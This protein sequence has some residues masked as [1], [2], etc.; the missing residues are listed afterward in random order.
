M[1][2]PNPLKKY[3]GTRSNNYRIRFLKKVK[4]ARKDK[5]RYLRSTFI[6]N[7]DFYFRKFYFNSDNHVPEKRS[8]KIPDI[9]LKKIMSYISPIE[10]EKVRSVCRQ[11]SLI[12]GDYENCCLYCPDMD[13]HTTQVY[14]C[15]CRKTFLH[16]DCHL[17]L[18]L[19]TRITCP[20]CG[21]ILASIHNS[22]PLNEYDIYDFYT[23]F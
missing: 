16:V 8:L 20:Y 17:K 3:N 1:E 6:L 7:D 23:I 15:F 14:K 10:R 21:S 5:N 9:I 4:S 13:Q 18:P 19:F 22:D 2:S 12:A 11:W